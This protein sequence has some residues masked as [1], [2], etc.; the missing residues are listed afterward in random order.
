[1][2]NSMAVQDGALLESKSK[3]MSK[4][5]KVIYYL[6][7]RSFDIACSI[8]GLVFMIP[9]I[10]IVKISYILT[11]DFKSIFYTQKR[12]GKNGKEFN[13]FKFRSM[14]PNAD[15]VLEK[16]LKENKDLRKEYQLNKKLRNDP[17]ITKMG[18]ILRKTSLDELPQVLNIL[19]GDM[20]VIGNRPYLPREKKDMGKSFDIIVK[21][22][23]GLTGY[24]QVSG[25]SDTTFK[26]RLELEEYYSLHAGLKLDIKIFFKTFAVVLFKKG[27]K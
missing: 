4:I 13:F 1:M 10:L 26:R 9:L 18:N 24:W 17:R 6:T 8:I 20:T 23:P 11:G 3:V 2:N 14:I 21:T 16:L 5:K 15:L 25:R 12:I 7:K 27:A 19:K 22:K